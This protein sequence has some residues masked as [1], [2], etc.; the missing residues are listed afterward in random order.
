MQFETKAY[1]KTITTKDN[2]TFQVMNIYVNGVLTKSYF[3]N[4]SIDKK[5][6]YLNDKEA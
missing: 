2:K 5:K 4:Y 6:V 1:I 3:V